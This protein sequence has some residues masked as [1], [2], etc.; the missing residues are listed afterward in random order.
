MRWIA[1]AH[2]EDAVFKVDVVPLQ[3]EQ[4]ATAQAEPNRNHEKG[5][6]TRRAQLQHRAEGPD[7]DRRQSRRAEFARAQP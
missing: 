7:R 6:E 2:V 1:R 4:F 3:A 5:F